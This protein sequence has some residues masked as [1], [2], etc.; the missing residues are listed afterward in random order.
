MRLQR[1]VAVAL[2]QEA[3][4]DA[5]VPFA[6]AE[7]ARFAWPWS[8]SGQGVLNEDGLPAVRLSASGEPPPAADAPVSADRL[9]AFG[10][11]ALR[12]LSALETGPRVGSAP[13]H[14]LSVARKELPG[15][16]VRLLVLALL[17]PALLLTVDAVA[18][19]RRRHE[20]PSL[21]RVV[22]AAIPFALGALLPG[23]L[24]LTGAVAAT[25]PPPLPPAA[26]LDGSGWA[27]IGCTVAVVVLATPG[28]SMNRTGHKQTLVSSHPANKN[29]VR[30]G[31]FSLEFSSR[32]HGDR[33]RP[34]V[35]GA[36][37][38]TRG[39]LRRRSAPLLP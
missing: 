5:G 3:Q 38:S 19:A 16:A 13:S 4:V 25:A 24:G 2:R 34:D 8:P 30:H 22:I 18:R 10:R 23:G 35:G 21:G 37:L 31:V 36:H 7:L 32:E 11:S 12:A 27:A 1:T 6:R 33:R 15:W 28:A 9:G 29:A 17:L 20:T 39:W 26:P 14:D